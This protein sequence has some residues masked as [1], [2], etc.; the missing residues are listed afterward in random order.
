[1]DFYHDY[2]LCWLTL[3]PTQ[4]PAP[5]PNVALLTFSL[6]HTHTQEHAFLNPHCAVT[7]STVAVKRSN[8]LGETQPLFYPMEA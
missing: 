3:L 1:M 4:L 7:F 2:T 6:S 5:N 8:L